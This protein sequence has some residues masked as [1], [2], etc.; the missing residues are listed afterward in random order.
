MSD[1]LNLLPDN[2][3]AVLTIINGAVTAV[4]VISSRHRIAT[5]ESLI[6]LL[7]AAGYTVTKE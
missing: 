3:R 2:G 5:L 1:F 6:E 4:T 7:Q